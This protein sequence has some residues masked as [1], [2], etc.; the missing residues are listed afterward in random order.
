MAAS[1]QA[2]MIVDIDA[3]PTISDGTAGG[4]E[5][6]SI[7]FP[8]CSELVDEW[9]LVSEEKICEALRLVIDTEHQLIEGAAA[10][11]IAAGIEAGEAHPN[12]TIAVV[13]C[14]ANISTS[15]LQVALSSAS[16]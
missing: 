6:G 15:M 7:T 8:L 2:G 10:V 1:V 13:S 14:G 4:V 9:T 5:A 12:Q 16:R 3:S 11:A